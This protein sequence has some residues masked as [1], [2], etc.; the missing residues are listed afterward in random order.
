MFEGTR[1]ARLHFTPIP[2]PV[3]TLSERIAPLEVDINDIDMNDPSAGVYADLY[4]KCSPISADIS[5]HRHQTTCLVHGDAASL[6]GY[7]HSPHGHC[8]LRTTAKSSQSQPVLQPRR[9]HHHD[10]SCARHSRS[11]DDEFEKGEGG[12]SLVLAEEDLS[13]CG[14]PRR[15][16]D[17]IRCHR[18]IYGEG[19]STIIPPDYRLPY[20]Q[21]ARKH[22]PQTL[23]SI[24]ERSYYDMTGRPQSKSR[25]VEESNI[26]SASGHIDHLSEINIR[27][28]HCI[29]DLCTHSMYLHATPDCG[30][31][32]RV[33]VPPQRDDINGNA[34]ME[35]CKDYEAAFNY[36]VDNSDGGRS[37]DRDTFHAEVTS[38][39]PVT[40][41][42]PRE[43]RLPIADT[44]HSHCQDTSN[45]HQPNTISAWRHPRGDASSPADDDSRLRSSRRPGVT[46]TC[47][48]DEASH[49][50]HARRRHIHRRRYSRTGTLHVDDTENCPCELA[51]SDGSATSGSAGDSV[52]LTTVNF[53]MKPPTSP[54]TSPLESDHLPGPVPRPPP[55]S[56]A[57][58]ISTLETEVAITSY[59]T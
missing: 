25:V 32:P 46:G 31:T 33:A 55:L 30:H 10:V 39:V 41:A 59:V 6:R 38:C 4:Q 35:R 20:E 1:E 56:P 14:D 26:A 52:D 34:I 13:W 2:R 49:D 8:S 18:P 5:R 47:C 23:H 27:G 9:G 53:P 29:Y 42:R 28:E 48:V 7:P 58:D 40:A 37:S 19:C 22:S 17:Y 12:S 45:A 16:G 44:F 57:L 24:S 3:S 15:G 21:A 11:A 51:Q 43:G 54:P 36:Y 50:R